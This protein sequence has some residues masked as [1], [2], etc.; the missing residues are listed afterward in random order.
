MKKACCGRS[1]IG[2]SRF[3]GS[4]STTTWRSGTS[5]T[6]PPAQEAEQVIEAADEHRTCVR[7]R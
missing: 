2:T 5:H 6:W 3:C 1:P 4:C 7:V